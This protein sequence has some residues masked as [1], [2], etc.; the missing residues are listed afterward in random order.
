MDPLDW[1]WDYPWDLRL[2]YR[3]DWQKDLRLDL[4]LDLQLAVDKLRK[5]LILFDRALCSLPNLFTL[6]VI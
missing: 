3:L 5:S 1:Q 6:T 2:G 4:R